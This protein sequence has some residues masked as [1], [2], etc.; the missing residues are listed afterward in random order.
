M[1]TDPCFYCPDLPAVGG[2]HQLSE[3]ESRHAGASRRI[4]A[5]DTISLLDGGGTLAAAVVDAVSRRALAFTVRERRTVPPPGTALT[6]ACAVPK[7]ERFR[8][9]VDMLT[10]IGVAG[11]VPLRC[12]RST[13]KPGP[14]TVDRGR[15]IAIEACKQSRNPFVPAIAQPVSVHESLARIPGTAVLAYAEAG[16]GA[17]AERLEESD[18]LCLYI[19]PEGGFTEAEVSALAGR[20]ARPVGLGG[21]ILRVEMAAVAG[22]VLAMIP[23]ERPA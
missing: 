21:N 3:E 18:S 22:A 8:T 9:M 14:S 12:E 15:R 4:R 7:G 16:G 10:Q 17:L 6:V 20:G 2:S 1:T 23:A 11:I 13:V 5:G 19:G